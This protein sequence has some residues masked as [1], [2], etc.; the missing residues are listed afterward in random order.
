MVRKHFFTFVLAV[1]FSA[2]CSDELAAKNRTGHAERL[3]L[4]AFSVF[5]GLQLAHRADGAVEEAVILKHLGHPSAIKE[6]QESDK[7]EP[8]LA[9]RYR[10]Y[11]YEGLEITTVTPQAGKSP[12]T[13]LERIV[14]TSQ[15]YRLSSGLHIGEPIASF[16]QVLGEAEA[17][18]DRDK[19]EVKYYAETI[20]MLDGVTF[21][22]H[23]T[24][25]FTIDKNE[26]VKA[27]SWW[28][29]AD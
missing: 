11:I 18:F 1:L 7:R 2:A 25:T 28:Y 19:G 14:V 27:I 10:T 23:V 29:W 22:G 12:G 4:F 3:T 21:A 15:Q 8:G 5:D 16:I 26:K 20:Q 9:N 6:L 13:W 17:P 24:I